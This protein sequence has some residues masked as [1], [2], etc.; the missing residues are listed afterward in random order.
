MDES[1]QLNWFKINFTFWF[2]I[3]ATIFAWLFY[4]ISELFWILWIDANMM[5]I[6]VNIFWWVFLFVVSY[7]K[8]KSFNIQKTDV[9]KL[10]FSSLF[11]FALWY[12]FLYQSIF[13]IWSSKTSFV[14]QIEPLFIF[15]LSCVFLR[16]KFSLRNLLS[17]LVI[18]FWVF[19][20]LFDPTF[21]KFG[22]GNWE[23]FGILSGLSFAMGI[24]F[25]VDIVKKYDEGIITW[26]QM[27]LWWFMLIIL[28]PSAVYNIKLQYILPMVILGI[29]MWLSWWFYNL[30]IKFLWI[31]KTAIIYASRSFVVFLFAILASSIFVNIGFKI[32]QNILFFILGGFVIFLWIALLKKD[33][34]DNVLLANKNNFVHSFLKRRFLFKQ[35]IKTK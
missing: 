26:L 29:F 1:H 25:I 24:L 9:I 28:H 15:L 6:C 18:L 33:K 30:S 13:L 20:I 8:I 31:S 17:L 32:P 34:Q 10:F 21:G 19:L 14:I 23:L 12:F 7:K 5:A 35:E 2:P 3:L 27:F 4:I 16:E 22:L 11:G